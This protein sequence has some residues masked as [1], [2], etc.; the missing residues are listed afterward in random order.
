MHLY[1]TRRKHIRGSQSLGWERYAFPVELEEEAEEAKEAK[2]RC[3]HCHT[4][5]QGNTGTRIVTPHP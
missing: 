3:A 2:G 1:G 4:M 5:S